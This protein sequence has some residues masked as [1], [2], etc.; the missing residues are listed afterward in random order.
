VAVSQNPLDLTRNERGHLGF[1]ARPAF[2]ANFIWDV[3]LMREQ[4]G[5]LGRALGGWQLNG[6]LRVNSGRRFTPA[7][8]S[9][10][11]NPY[12][13]SGLMNAFCGT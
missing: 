5:F 3:P 1:D 8:A 12:E 10:D 13:D 11:R 9:T 7:H 4:K 2:T 6:I